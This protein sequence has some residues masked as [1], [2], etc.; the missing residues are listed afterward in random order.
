M[1]GVDIMSLFLP[2]NLSPNFEEV[3][4]NYIN[5]NT[6]DDARGVNLEFEFQVNTNGSL[7]RS[8]K[9]EILN[10]KND[11]EVPED[12]IL[13]T[14]Y[15]TFEPPLYNKDIHT[16]TLDKNTIEEQV[17][18]EISKDYRWRIRLYEDQIYDEKGN[19]NIQT[20]YGNTY[21]GAGNVVGSTKNVIWLNKSNDK[22]V[23]DKYIQT[24]LYS[25]DINNDFNP[26][27]IK[28]FSKNQKYID[29]VTNYYSG[30][31]NIQIGIFSEKYINADGKI[32][33]FQINLN[34]ILPE[35]RKKIADGNMYFMIPRINSKGSQYDTHN[36]PKRIIGFENTDD[37]SLGANCIIKIDPLQA[38]SENTFGN[39]MAYRLVYIQRQQIYSVGN[40]IGTHQLTKIT[41]DEPLDYNIFHKQHI[42]TGLV[43]DN[44]DYGRVYIDPVK[45][46]D[47]KLVPSAYINIAY[48][49]NQ[50]IDVATGE[51]Y[52]L[53]DT[54][55][56]DWETNCERYFYLDTSRGID[57]YKPVAK[58]YSVLESKPAKWE[59]GAYKQYYE[60]VIEYELIKKSD[61]A[62]VWPED[63]KVPYFSKNEAGEYVTLSGQQ[64]PNNWSTEYYTKYYIEVEKYYSLNAYT[65]GPEYKENQYFYYGSPPFPLSNIEYYSYGISQ[66]FLS[67][68]NGSLACST[69]TTYVAKTG[70]CALFSDLKFKPD[71]FYMYQ[72]F[73]VDQEAPNYNPANSVNPYKFY[74]GTSFKDNV[75]EDRYYLGG[76]NGDLTADFNTRANLLPIYSNH[77]IGDTNQFLC[78]IQPNSGIYEDKYKPCMLQLYNNQYQHDLYITNYNGSNEYN[79]DYSIDTLD[80]SQWLVALT[81]VNDDSNLES[82]VELVQKPQTK[83]KIYTNFVNSIP[84]AYFYYRSDKK[85]EFE[86]LNFYTKET[87]ILTYHDNI[88]VIPQRD[89]YVKCRIYDSNDTLNKSKNLVTIKYYKYIIAEANINDLNDI[90]NIIYESDY[91]YDGKFEYAIKGLTSIYKDKEG[92]VV[93]EPQLYRIQIIAEDEYGRLYQFAEDVYFGYYQDIV[94]DRI[95]AEVDCDNQAVHIEFSPVK[96][97]RGEGDIKVSDEITFVSVEDEDGLEFRSLQDVAD[98][99]IS[100]P[101]D[102]ICYTKLKIADKMFDQEAEQDILVIEDD[103]HCQYKVTFDTRVYIKDLK[104]GETIINNDYLSFRLR[105]SNDKN[106]AAIPKVTIEDIYGAAIF[107]KPSGFYY[108]IDTED[109]NTT[110]VYMIETSTS[111]QSVD[112][113]TIKDTLNNNGQYQILSDEGYKIYDN[114]SLAINNSNKTRMGFLYF[115]ITPTSM[116]IS[117]TNLD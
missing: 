106:D 82:C 80:D 32:D 10:D 113:L 33:G 95:S 54:Q 22:I 11:A 55:P 65:K 109:E 6:G 59:S 38:Y 49:D 75:V 110:G 105:T 14:F 42:E 76:Y 96:T 81:Y 68:Y 44:F 40:S 90:G 74:A 93:S 112:Q 64:E 70:E 41:L 97:F 111:E 7:V 1:K 79:K 56:D 116:T 12:N 16:I 3:I 98:N 99:E 2:S 13:A 86:Y 60:K 9:L 77:Q 78:F 45:E 84:E 15:G 37:N 71:R 29:Y 104:T 19:I 27:N 66:A 4:P 89:V 57:I 72:I 73:I 103:S 94:N 8:Y 107:N 83:Y 21:V 18:L 114:D 43:S 58:Q 28:N 92:T 46:F 62:P 25:D 48:S 23:E 47:S 87:L 26:F 20:V 88:K 39:L 24:T 108:M 31:T 117:T 17:I 34:D 101:Q 52:N 91:L 85:L 35:Y 50:L 5:D 67:S 30:N 102:F 51:K 53:L 36:L 63:N 115:K 100:I 69:L 61:Q